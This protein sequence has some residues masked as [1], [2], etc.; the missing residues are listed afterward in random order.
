MS[1]QQVDS[2]HPN[3]SSYI[4]YISVFVP[5][6]PIPAPIK[7]PIGPPNTVP[8]INPALAPPKKCIHDIKISCKSN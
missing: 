1:I 5:T 3:R 4:T 2:F 8:I 7:P 6:P